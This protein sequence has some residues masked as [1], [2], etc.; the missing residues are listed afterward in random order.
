M[1]C[2]SEEWSACGSRVMA[3]IS[4]TLASQFLSVRSF[5]LSRRLLRLFLRQSCRQ[6]TSQDRCFERSWEG[7]RV[8]KA[9]AAL[10]ETDRSRGEGLRC[11]DD[12]GNL[13]VEPEGIELANF[14]ERGRWQQLARELLARIYKTASADQQKKV[15][16]ARRTDARFLTCFLRYSKFA[17][18]S[19]CSVRAR[20]STVKAS[21]AV[22]SK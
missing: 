3:D 19:L 8:R 2:C 7:G 1:L 12:L 17:C 9:V 16:R 4:R 18:E 6:E 15:S 20:S 11:R 10:N 14:E 13:R 22:G 5:C 21:T